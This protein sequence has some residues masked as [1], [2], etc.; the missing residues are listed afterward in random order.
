MWTSKCYYETITYLV[1]DT[2]HILHVLGNQIT[3][4]A[5]IMVVNVLPIYASAMA[6]HGND[7]LEVAMVGLEG[8]HHGDFVK[9]KVVHS[10]QLLFT[11]GSSNS[12]ELAEISYPRQNQQQ[13]Q[14]LCFGYMSKKMLH[15]NQVY[16]NSNVR[17]T[18]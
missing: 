5:M 13:L 4:L 11:V 6:S 8:S 10:H 14:N 2:I 9:P 15:F 7:P 12:H 18:Y 1:N 3:V 17:R 16:K